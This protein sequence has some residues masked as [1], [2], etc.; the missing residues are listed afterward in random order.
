MRL[1]RH[2]KETLKKEI[3]ACLSELPEVQRVV[4]FGSFVDSDHPHDLDIA[5][6]QDSDE[7]YYALAMKYRRQLTSV[8]DKIAIDVIPIRPDPGE[9]PFLR[10]I[11][12]GEVLY[13]R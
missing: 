10:E 8:A 9:G 4:V 3:A 2:L 7:K 11:D 12:K 5:V 6:F 13:E 1:S